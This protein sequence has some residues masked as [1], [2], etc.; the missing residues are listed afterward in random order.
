M[1]LISRK[2]LLD[3][4]EKEQQIYEDNC[5]SP[6]FWTALSVVRHMPTVEAKPVVHGEWIKEPGDWK[7]STTGEPLTVHQCS[8]CRSYFIH[9]PYNFCPNC[10]ADMRKKVAE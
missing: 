4:L 6:S 2:V 8:N 7:S 3:S 9:A 10:G 5:S 1:D